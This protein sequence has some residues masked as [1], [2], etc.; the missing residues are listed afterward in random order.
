M[1]VS[2]ELKDVVVLL[3]NAARKLGD[4]PEDRELAS[5]SRRAR[6]LADE[7]DQ[8]AERRAHPERYS[9]ELRQGAKSETPTR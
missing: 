9:V 6:E 7:L 5:F 4:P 2:A 1:T 8:V 3:H